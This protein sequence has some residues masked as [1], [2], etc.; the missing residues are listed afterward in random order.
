MSANLK[1]LKSDLLNLERVVFNPGMTSD[2]ERQARELILNIKGT[3]V[4]LDTELTAPPF[5]APGDDHRDRAL[6]LVL[7]EMDRQDRKWGP[8]RVQS[9]GK[10]LA[11]LVEEVGEV[12]LA[13]NDMDHAKG[14]AFA[15]LVRNHEKEWVQVAAVAVQRV[16]AIRLAEHQLAAGQ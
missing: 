4:L 10:W 11:I 14:A 1:Q 2:L 15:E 5:L 12:A 6:T 9:L 13:I 16:K 3:L 7:A 8:N